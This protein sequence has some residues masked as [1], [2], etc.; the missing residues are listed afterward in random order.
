MSVIADYVVGNG[1]VN[2][3]MID[4]YTTVLSIEQRVAPRTE[5]RLIGAFNIYISWIE[6]TPALVGPLGVECG[7][8]G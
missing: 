8:R 7:L 6:E 4:R 2:M 1:V 3:K 5:Q